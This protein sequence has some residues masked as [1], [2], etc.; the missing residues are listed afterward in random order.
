MLSAI[1]DLM[2]PPS[3]SRRGIGFTTELELKR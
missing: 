1:R 3:P 2:N